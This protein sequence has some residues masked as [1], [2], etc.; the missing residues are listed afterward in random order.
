[1]E[2][3]PPGHQPMQQENPSTEDTDPENS[4]RLDALGAD[5]P[6]SPPVCVIEGCDTNCPGLHDGRDAHDREGVACNRCWAYHDRHNHWPDE[7][8]DIDFCPECEVDAGAVK[9]DCP[10][11]GAV[12]IIVES[13]NDCPHCGA[14]QRP[15]G[16][17]AGYPNEC[18][19]CR[20]LDYRGDDINAP[21]HS[22]EVA[23]EDGGTK[24]VYLCERCAEEMGW[25]DDPTLERLT[26]ADGGVSTAAPAADPADIESDGLP[27]LRFADRYSLEDEVLYL[28]QHEGLTTLYRV[29]GRTP[30]ARGMLA[31]DAVIHTSGEAET[32]IAS[33]TYDG[34]YD[35]VDLMH[36]HAGR[37]ECIQADKALDEPAIALA[38]V[39]HV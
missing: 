26:L 16:E 27:E 30:T 17:M 9:H 36:W 28:E 13:G 22:I 14:E 39:E 24:I 4:L 34:K 21:T 38:E 35:V 3:V 6:D 25:A 1:M 29:V 33:A 15:D 5:N 2:A 20:L 11:R 12:T 7:E 32:T 31:H 19:L 37:V 23:R 18:Q 8:S 10:E